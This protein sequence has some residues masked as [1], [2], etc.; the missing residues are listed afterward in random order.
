M[1]RGLRLPTPPPGFE[2]DLPRLRSKV[3]E[4][5]AMYAPYS[6]EQANTNVD[7]TESPA[8]S[9]G[10]EDEGSEYEEPRPSKR[11]RRNGKVCGSV[12]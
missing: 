8:L 3:R 11:R 10:S 6:F 5:Q 1:T 2:L 7:A 4:L 12:F 9:E